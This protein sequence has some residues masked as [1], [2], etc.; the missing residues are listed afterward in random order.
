MKRSKDSWFKAVTRPFA[1]LSLKYKLY[2]SFT[3]LI[4]LLVAFAGFAYYQIAAIQDKHV[5]A[6]AVARNLEQ[7]FS[8]MQTQQLQLTD[9]LN[10]PYNTAFYLRRQSPN[11]A[12]WEANYNTLTDGADQL[13]RLYPGTA[14]ADRLEGTKPHFTAYRDNFLQ[15]ISKYQQRGFKDFGREGTMRLRAQELERTL[16]NPADQVLLLQMRRAE[17][18]FFLRQEASYIETFNRYA[19]QLRARLAAANQK[20]LAEEYTNLF[21]E[22][23]TLDKQIGLTP[24]DGLRGRMSQT[25]STTEPAVQASTSEVLSRTSDSI[26]A[27]NRTLI[28]VAVVFTIIA[29]TLAAVISRFITRRLQALLRATRQIGAGMLQHRI[30][31]TN[32]DELGMLAGGFNSMADR[33]QAA[34]QELDERAAALAG[35]VKKFELASKAVNEAIYDWDIHADTLVWGEGLHTVFGYGHEQLQTSIS[36]W[37]DRIHPDDAPKVNDTLDKVFAKKKSYWAAGYRFKRHDGQYAYVEDRGFIE[38]ESGEPVRMVGSLIDITRQRELDRAKDEFISVASH[39]L[40]TPLGGIR[41][42][43]ELILEESRR[44]SKETR[45]VLQTA[46]KSTLRMIGLVNDLLSVARIEQHRVQDTP[47]PTQL[48]EVIRMAASEMAPLIKQADVTLAIVEKGR[49]APVVLDAKRFREAIQNLMS[50][51]VKY[52]PARGRVTV[53]LNYSPKDIVISVADTGIGIPKEDLHHL[54]QKFFR[55]SNVTTTDTEGSGLGLFVVKSYVEAWGG[56]IWLESEV[57]KGTT[58]YISIPAKP[59]RQRIT[60]QQEK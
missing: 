17:K 24:N 25:L 53:T 2:G 7:A 20:T 36:W 8:D 52:T 34:R 41:W 51:A 40:R 35:S 12:A 45:E 6:R 60:P 5:P 54:F 31:V 14:L 10:S 43:L 13:I 21:N 16:S 48:V 46:Y 56:K 29:I 1:R 3:V 15:I 11:F 19:S 30:A 38:Y 57:N 37:T 49:A 4:L 9:E 50:N 22:I 58:F 32:T 26:A 55:A 59:R 39:Q 47:A 28:P 27:I 23:A 33:L 44:F 42:N 18:D